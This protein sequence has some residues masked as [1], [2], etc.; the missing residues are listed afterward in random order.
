MA[1]PQLEVDL[2]T[3]LL[4]FFYL[5]HTIEFSHKNNATERYLGGPIL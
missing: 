4:I 1:P 2:E 5:P 3:S